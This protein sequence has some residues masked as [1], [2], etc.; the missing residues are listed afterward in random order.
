MSVPFF[1][2]GILFYIIEWKETNQ[3]MAL[4]TIPSDQIDPLTSAFLFRILSDLNIWTD[5]TVTQSDDIFQWK[6]YNTRKTLSYFAVKMSQKGRIANF[7]N[8]P[9]GFHCCKTWDIRNFEF[10]TKR[11]LWIL[12]KLSYF[13]FTHLR[14]PLSKVQWVLYG[15]YVRNRYHQKLDT[16]TVA[17][18]LEQ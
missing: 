18:K 2:F 3:L 16:W 5:V 8:S 6:I 13:I 11:F 7:K 12:P 9:I 15:M 17:L 4:S 14:T 10:G 1:H